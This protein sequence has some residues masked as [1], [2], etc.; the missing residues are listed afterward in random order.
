MQTK[1]LYSFQCQDTCLAFL[2]S[3]GSLVA[4]AY[5]GGALTFHTTVRIQMLELTYLLGVLVNYEVLYDEA[6]RRASDRIWPM[7]IVSPCAS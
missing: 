4:R 6:E 3:D 5:S 1:N 7:P 2:A